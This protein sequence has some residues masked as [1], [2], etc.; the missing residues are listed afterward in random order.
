M[1]PHQ[2]RVLI[3]SQLN[4]AESSSS[5][6]SETQSRKLRFNDLKQ[7]PL[8]DKFKF[9]VN[10]KFKFKLVTC[11]LRARLLFALKLNKTHFE[12]VS[13]RKVDLDN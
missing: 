4:S 7:S 2:E 9:S 8:T 5:R 1:N 3:T 12:T 13:L 10:G 11:T 6:E